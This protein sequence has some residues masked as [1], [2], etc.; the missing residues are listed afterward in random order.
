MNLEDVVEQMMW[1][2]PTASE[3]RQGWQPRV[4]PGKGNQQSLSTL[5]MKSE[6]REP[7]KDWDGGQLNPEW[8]EWLMGYKIG[9]TDLS[10]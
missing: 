7:N 8:V 6:G 4:G 10:N 9:H 5:V 3:A 2:T 1:P